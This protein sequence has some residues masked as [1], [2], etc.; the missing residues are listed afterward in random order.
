MAIKLISDL[1]LYTSIFYIP[2]NVAPELSAPLGPSELGLTAAY[3]LHTLT[4]PEEQRPAHLPALH[5]ILAAAATHEPSTRPRLYLACALTP[6][7]GLTYE[8]SKQ[9]SHLAVEAAIRES[10]KLGVQNHYLDGIPE[11]FKAADTLKNPTPSGESERVRMGNL[12]SFTCTHRS[13]IKARL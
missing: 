12:V 1:D 5:P 4:L 6:Y 11:L 10:T 2:S 9:K 3:I 13:L 8:D 7:R